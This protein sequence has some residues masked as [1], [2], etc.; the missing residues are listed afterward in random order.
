MPVHR[1]TSLVRQVGPG[2]EAPDQLVVSHL[3][4]G[5]KT[6]ASKLLQLLQAAV[7]RRLQMNID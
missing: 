7:D 5:E 2:G 4:K 3:K 6:G 1:V